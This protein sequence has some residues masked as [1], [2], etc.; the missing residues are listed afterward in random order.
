V[1][2]TRPR[3]RQSPAKR[4]ISNPKDDVPATVPE[5]ENFEERGEDLDDDDEDEDYREPEPIAEEMEEVET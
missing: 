3:R 5:E 1:T 2:A 4:H